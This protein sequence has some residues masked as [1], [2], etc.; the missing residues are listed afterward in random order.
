MNILI[1]KR[2]MNIVRYYYIVLIACPLTLQVGWAS[3]EPGGKIKI[4]PQSLPICTIEETDGEEPEEENSNKYAIFE[5]KKIKE[6]S[7]EGQFTVVVKDPPQPH[8]GYTLEKKKKYEWTVTE[9]LEVENKD[10][11]TCTVK[12]STKEQW[13]KEITVKCKMSFYE[14]KDGQK[15]HLTDLEA[16]HKLLTPLILIHQISFN[17]IPGK[18]EKDALDLK[19]SYAGKVISCPEVTF[20][21]DGK[22]TK[23]DPF[24]YVGGKKPTLKIKAEVKP[25]IIEKAKIKTKDEEGST[26]NIL[27]EL[28]EQEFENKKIEERKE[29]EITFKEDIESKLNKGNQKWTWRLIE[30]QGTAL[31]K[32]TISVETIVKNAY[33]LFKEP[34][35]SPWNMQDDTKKPWV[36]ALNVAIEDAGNIDL[37]EKSS[38]AIVANIA[39]HTFGRGWTYDT[40]SGAPKYSSNNGAIDLDGYLEK[41]NGNVVNCYDQCFS[42]S[43]LARLLGINATGYFQKP[44]GQILVVNLIGVGQCNNP[45]YNNP[46]YDMNPYNNYPSLKKPVVDKKDNAYNLRSGFKN[47]AYVQFSGSVFDACAGPVVG[48]APDAYQKDTIENPPALPRVQQKVTEFK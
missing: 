32:Q 37:N 42:L 21:Q 28:D 22:A 34:L 16:V 24:L 14:S 11:E 41:N 45:F 29:F 12:S 18:H 47:H 8:A 13:G 43:A 44:F 9:K 15:K 3:G 25:E 19:E 39:R 2:Q 27:P 46:N 48:V 35:H 4:E 26:K 6:Y 1:D 30:I 10:Q 7:A 5:P 40:T 23:S 38:S 20:D 31:T 17:H 33:V 36:K